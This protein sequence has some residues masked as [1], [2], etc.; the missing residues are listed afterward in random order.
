MENNMIQEKFFIAIIR[1]GVYA[2]LLMPLVVVPVLAPFILGKA[3]IFRILVEISLAAYLALAFFCP[4]YRPRL[5]GLLLAISAFVG[6]L[7]LTAVTG[8]NFYHSFWSSPYRME[9][10]FM[11]LHLWVFFIIVSSV[12]HNTLSTTNINTKSHEDTKHREEIVSDWKKFFRLAIVVS[13]LVSGIALAQHVGFLSSFVPGTGATSTI[14]NVSFL[15]AY[16]IFPVFLALALYREDRAWRGFYLAS[17]LL[18]IAVIFLTASRGGILGLTLGLV[19]WG[20]LY[21]IFCSF[22][23]KLK[24]AVAGIL[25]TATLFSAGVW[26]YRDS[27]IIQVIPAL[28]KIT[29]TSFEET[30]TR[31][32]LIAWQIGLKGWRE[33]LWLGWGPENFY[34]PFD[35]YFNPELYD[36]LQEKPW[37]DRAHNIFLEFGVTSGL[38]GVLVYFSIF[39][40]V[41]WS[42][43]KWWNKNRVLHASLISLLFAYLAQNMFSIDSPSSLILFFLVLSFA[44]AF[45]VPRQEEKKERGVWRVRGGAF[46]V[47]LSFLFAGVLGLM[48]WGNVRPLIAAYHSHLAVNLGASNFEQARAQMTNAFSSR[49]FVNG[50]ASRELADIAKKVEK[51]ADVSDE[52]KKEFLQFSIQMLEKNVKEFYMSAVRYYSLLGETYGL[53]ALYD[54]KYLKDAEVSFD[55]A[56]AHSPKRLGLYWGKG[57]LFLRQKDSEN[58]IKWYKKALEIAPENRTALWELGVAHAYFGENA[59]GLPLME[60]AYQAGYGVNSVENHVTLAKVYNAIG[61]YGLTVAFLEKAVVLNAS[62]AV[63]MSQLAAAYLKLGEKEKARETA[64][65][66]GQLEPRLLPQVEQFLEENNLYTDRHR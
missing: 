51:R 53:L 33:R 41:F 13:V 44:G 16:L 21:S 66:A 28:R 25:L 45:Y 54:K 59:E 8:E 24:I 60:R 7:I 27:S 48:Y 35:K 20:A 6:V 32:R 12:F 49:T 22:S 30:T 4:Q 1:W 10:L 29:S 31:A 15:A 18:N 37:F 65:K 46:A 61:D 57:L 47:L 11:Y 52:A 58:S 34:M 62:D 50:E 19:L 64:L 43:K 5:S 9:G 3:V 63:L 26:L 39:G 17:F 23:S 56:T 2:I 42:I 36:I 40:A 38:V 14:G 55:Q